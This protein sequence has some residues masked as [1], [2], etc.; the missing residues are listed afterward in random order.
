MFRYS[1]KPYI[2]NSVTKKQVCELWC[3]KVME[4]GFAVMLYKLHDH[5]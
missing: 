4:I 5:A 3:T 1:T 2:Q